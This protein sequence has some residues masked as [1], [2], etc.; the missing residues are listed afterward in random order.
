MA[1]IL[2][3]LTGVEELLLLEAP[4]C[5]TALAL[6]L[7]DRLAQRA[8]EVEETDAFFSGGLCV[9]DV[10]ALLLY[11]RSAIFGDAIRSDALCPRE[12]CGARFDMAFRISEY[13]AHHRPR[14]P[15][16][17]E[18]AEET[19]WFRLRDTPVSFR[20]PT[21][22]D[23][24]AVAGRRDAEREMVRRCVR[25]AGAAARLVRRAETAMEVLAPRLSRELEGACLECG[26]KVTLYFD[27]QQFTLLELRDQ[28]VHLYEDVHLLA[29]SFHW[30]EE[31]ILALPQ[32]RRALYAERVREER[33]QP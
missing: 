6:A 30:P 17:L 15:R 2:R 16:G 5:D 28:S 26:A 4:I 21:G 22:A 1:V 24:A 12:S 10:D 8:E 31:A 7:L 29:S 27:V 32:R 33:S 23:Q 20:L 3:P 14:T 9:T 18:M 13:L 19:G 11:L 25:P